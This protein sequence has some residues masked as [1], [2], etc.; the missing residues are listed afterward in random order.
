LPQPTV[1]MKAETESSIR[2]ESKNRATSIQASPQAARKKRFTKLDISTWETTR[3]DG[4]APICKKSIR[5]DGDQEEVPPCDTTRSSGSIGHLAARNHLSY[6]RKTIDLGLPQCQGPEKRLA[7]AK[8]GKGLDG[9][10]LSPPSNSSPTR[11]PSGKGRNQ[12]H[13][14]WN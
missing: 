2:Q 9:L 12:E 5:Q 6:D 11:A 1:L 13:R 14:Q 7:Q 8:K 3:S 4:T 10:T